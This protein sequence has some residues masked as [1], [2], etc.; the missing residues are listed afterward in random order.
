M[1]LAHQKPY[2]IGD[3]EIISEKL[4]VI[5]LAS[6]MTLGHILRA[7]SL[8]RLNPTQMLYVIF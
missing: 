7:R 4:D 1:L 2:Y 8:L 3:Q 6:S 5:E